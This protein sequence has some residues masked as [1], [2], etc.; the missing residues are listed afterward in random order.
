[1]RRVLMLVSVLLCAG[2]TDNDWASVMPGGSLWT[3]SS[4]APNTAAPSAAPS[5]AAAANYSAFAAAP[6]GSP[7]ATE[8]CAH[9][10]RDRTSDAEA[11]GFDDTVQKQV[12]DKTYADCM[13]WAAHAVWH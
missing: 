2:C 6:V 4:A 1:M 9:A 13:S 5:A 11:Q 7:T 8:K 12:Y 3:Y 10:A